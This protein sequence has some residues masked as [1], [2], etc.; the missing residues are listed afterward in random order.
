[1]VAPRG[2]GGRAL[3]AE[4]RALVGLLQPLQD[5]AADAHGRL[6]G[7]DVRRRRTS[8]RRRRRPV[9]RGC[10]GRC[11]G[12]CR[13]P[14][15]CGRTPRR[16]RRSPRARAGIALRAAPRAGTGSPRPARRSPAAATVLR[17]PSRMSTGSKPVGTMGTRY[18]SAM[19]SYS[20]Q[21]MTVQTWPAA[22]KP[23]T[24]LVGDDEDR[25]H[26]RR[27]QHVADDLAEVGQA[28][29]RGLLQRPWRCP[30]RWSRSPRP[31][32]RPR[33]RDSRGPASPPPAASRPC[34]RRRRGS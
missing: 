14:A 13:C 34:A 5:L 1:M 17:M 33:G 9:R 25:L 28:L 21:P 22:R 24:R 18:F 16:P 23:C 4:G 11:R 15:T 7:G 12:W 32:R 3:R 20:S 27:H 30:G 29:G 6:L 10:A 8:A 26:G 19:G 31:G 2:V